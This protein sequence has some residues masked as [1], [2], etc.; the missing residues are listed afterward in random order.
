MLKY[1][2]PLLILGLA[3]IVNEAIDRIMIKNLSPQDSAMHNLG[4]YAACFKIGVIMNLFIQAFRYSAEPF[5]FSLYK[6]KDAK[7]GYSVVMT[8]FVII[9]TF[10]F[11]AVMMYLDII[12]YFINK[13]YHEGL[14]IVPIILL[15]FMFLGICYNLSIWF[16]LTGQ[17]QYGAYITVGGAII[18]VTVNLVLIPTI[19]YIGA[20]W[21]HLMTYLAMT[22]ASYLIGQKFYPIPYNLKKILFYMLTALFLFAV[23]Y[24]VIPFALFGQYE[25]I[26]KISINTIILLLYTAIIFGREYKMIKRLV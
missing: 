25:S 8:Y 2:F 15:A 24:F 10:I 26:A 22:I 6:E 23:S 5:F 3:G 7:Q 19:G 4:V 20:A 9:C 17:T 18:T 11:L 16:K 21:G 13:N 1:A 12:K 14:T